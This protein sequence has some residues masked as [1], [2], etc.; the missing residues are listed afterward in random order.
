MTMRLHGAGWLGHVL[1]VLALLALSSP[2]HARHP[3]HLT[4]AR[5]KVALDGSFE[6][7][8][9]FD[10]LSFCLEI[11]AHEIAEGAI[12]ALLDGPKEA[13]ETALEEGKGLLCPLLCQR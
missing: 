3:G 8:V 13:L 4:A 7:K 1:A 6:L 9:R 12:N 2:S 5:A 11:P 10:V